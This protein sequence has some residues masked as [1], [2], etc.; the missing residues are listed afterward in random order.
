MYR[1]SAKD[2]FPY[3]MQRFIAVQLIPNVF[4]G[5]WKGLFRSDCDFYNQSFRI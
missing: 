2:V 4:C 5:F 3:H 1:V